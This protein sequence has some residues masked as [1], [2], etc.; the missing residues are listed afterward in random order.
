MDEK[1][2]QMVKRGYA[3]TAGLWLLALA[4][5]LMAIDLPQSFGFPFR[6]SES[7]PLN[8]LS[9]ASVNLLA[10]SLALYLD[11]RRP[12]SGKSIL[13]GCTGTIGAYGLWGLSS[14]GIFVI[15]AAV[16]LGIAAAGRRQ[17]R[18]AS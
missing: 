7:G 2:I 4:L 9:L 11:H 17:L 16:L 15:P 18:Q 13:W 8:F 1:S 6:D 14:I 3:L 10:I 12:G 5:V